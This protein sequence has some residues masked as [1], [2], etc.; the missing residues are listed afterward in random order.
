MFNTAK[1]EVEF[2]AESIWHD[3]KADLEPK[4]IG[5]DGSKVV[6]E[7]PEEVEKP[8]AKAPK[9]VEPAPVVEAKKEEPIKEEEPV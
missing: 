3:G 2:F 7:A 4:K 5:D 8:V 1:N 9:K 6:T